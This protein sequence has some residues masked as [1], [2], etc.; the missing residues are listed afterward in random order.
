MA[1]KIGGYLQGGHHGK[2]YQNTVN[3]ANSINVGYAV[4]STKLSN[5]KAMSRR[6]LEASGYSIGV[7]A[8]PIVL[9]SERSDFYSSG[10]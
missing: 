7:R 2:V 8:G 9:V 5:V 1:G 3:A 10:Y 4:M 6:L